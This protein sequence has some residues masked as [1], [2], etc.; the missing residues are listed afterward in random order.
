MAKLTDDQLR[1]IID[2]EAKGAQG[3]INSLS[4][5]IGKLEKQNASLSSSIS[6]V[7]NELEKQEK[8]LAKMEAAGKTNTAT[9]KQLAQS[10]ETNRQKQAQLTS[11][12]KQNQNALDK[13]WEKVA[14]FTSSLMLN[15]MTMQQLRERASQLRRQLDVTSKA[16]SPETYRN[17]QTKLANT[18]KAMGK[19]SV[20]YVIQKSNKYG[21][22]QESLEAHPVGVV[23]YVIQKSNKYGLKQDCGS[24]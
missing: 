9:Y 19:L 16:A 8:K 4:A 1:F 14:Q 6:N 18:E 23:V 22:K 12:L 2:I 10:V 3:Q 11:Q 5:E 13:D 17:L 7:N 20:V 21:L 15:Q 24:R